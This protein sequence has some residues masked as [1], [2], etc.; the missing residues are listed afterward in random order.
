MARKLGKPTDQRLALLNN[1]A[2]YLLWYGRIETTVERAKEIRRIAEKMLTLAINSYE[3]TVM[4]EKE[5]TNVKGE[6]V[7]VEFKNDGPLKLK[8]R[9]KMLSVLIPVHE[10][11]A[12]KE[13]MSDYKAR[14]KDINHPLIEK[15]FNEYAP[16]YA[17]RNKKQTQGGGYT[18]I[19][20][21]GERRG[22][23]A[24]MAII[25]LVS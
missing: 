13:K 16:R 25:E 2:S 1:Q 10:P 18:R 24:Q 4:V 19:I 21:I 5:K 9:R 20:R 11:M 8:A 3:D 14:V 7:N 15:I 22:D 17:E 23:A 6:K 12:D